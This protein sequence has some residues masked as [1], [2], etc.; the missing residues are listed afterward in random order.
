MKNLLDLHTHTISSGHAYS[1]LQE[2]VSA[3][4]A[5]GL[6]Y[7]GMSDHAPAIPG[8]PHIYH[9][10]NLRAIPTM[11][12][13]VHVL[14]GAELNILND[15]GEVDIPDSVLEEMDYAIASMHGPCIPQGDEEYYTNAYLNVMKNPYVRII[16]HPDDGRFPLN[17]EKFV[18][19]L[20]E[21][22]IIM[23]VNNASI[24]PISFRPGARENYH[25][26]LKLCAQ[27]RVPIIINTDAHIC[28]RIGDIDLA[29]K[30]L[31]EENFPKELV[32]NWNEELIEEY[33]LT[34][35]KK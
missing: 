12:D 30:M 31:E 24:S 9:F 16:G 7:Y 25:S 34:P 20:I 10:S 6:K 29:L 35:R 5:K 18:E 1:T 19:G 21:N 8:G 3:A 4:K 15:K 2:N 28:Y 33:I 11:I 13:G 17:H 22:H 27:K 32:L 14:R 23:E 26:L